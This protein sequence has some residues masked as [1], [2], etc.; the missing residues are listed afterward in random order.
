MY[1]FIPRNMY[2]Y[3]LKTAKPCSVRGFFWRSSN[4][5]F[6]PRRCHSDSPDALP[7]ARLQKLLRKVRRWGRDWVGVVPC[8]ACRLAAWEYLQSKAAAHEGNEVP[9]LSVLVHEALGVTHPDLDIAE[10]LTEVAVA[11]GVFSIG[12]RLGENISSFTSFVM[13]GCC[14]QQR[15]DVDCYGI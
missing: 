7:K 10:N 12:V 5:S 11:G 15:G 6:L 8:F 2:L 13:G 3:Y 4:L 9:G 14:T 1:Y